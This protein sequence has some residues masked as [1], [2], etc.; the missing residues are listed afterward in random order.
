MDIPDQI[1]TE[2]A[3]RILGCSRRTVQ[4]LIDRGRFKHVR[5]VVPDAVKPTYRL[6]RKEVERFRQ[7]QFVLAQAG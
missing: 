5:K 1:T 2:E 6:S 3:A 4:R 7:H